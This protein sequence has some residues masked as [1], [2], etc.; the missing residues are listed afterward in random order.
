MNNYED[1][2]LQFLLGNLPRDQYSEFIKSVHNSKELQDKLNQE[3][4]FEILLYSQ[5]WDVDELIKNGLFLNVS[6][7]LNKNELLDLLPP[8]RNTLTKSFYYIAAILLFTCTLY[9]SFLL[10]TNEKKSI[11][12]IQSTEVDTSKAIKSYDTIFPAE[13]YT[14]T[15]K[16]KNDIIKVIKNRSY[17]PIKISSKASYIEK[18]KSVFNIL[19][20]NDSTVIINLIKGELQFTVKTGSYK[21]FAVITNHAEVRVTGTIFSVYTDSLNTNTI[22]YRGSVLITDKSGTQTI[23]ESN[24][25]NKLKINSDGLK[26]SIVKELNIIDTNKSLLNNFLKQ[27]TPDF[28][29]QLPIDTVISDL[30]NI[31]FNLLNDIKNN[32]APE[33]NAQLMHINAARKLITD[34]KPK[35]AIAVLEKLLSE[36]LDNNVKDIA[37]IMIGQLYFKHDNNIYNSEFNRLLTASTTAD[38]YKNFSLLSLYDKK[39]KRMYSSFYEDTEKFIQ[40][41]PNE[42]HNYLLYW[43]L[44]QLDI[45]KGLF[46]KA[47]D[48]YENIIERY[49]NSPFTED[50]KYKLGWCLINRPKEFSGLK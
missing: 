38:I 11:P 6:D 44:A 31:S 19:K 45:N 13:N 42:R 47:I 5:Q 36:H 48:R 21:K 40:D 14:E 3:A 16:S 34:N 10:H 27:Y 29:N 20:N 30:N 35:D 9:L 17:Q 33:V 1:Q 26:K 22:V 18:Q 46:N 24:Q 49:P 32:L 15:E 25:S 39:E 41:Y 7:E 12:I 2:I 37:I 4:S 23:L 50:A 28:K 8:K 43:H